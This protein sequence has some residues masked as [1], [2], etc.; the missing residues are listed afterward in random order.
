[1]SCGN[2]VAK[3]GEDE[4]GAGCT[5]TAEIGGAGRGGAGRGG[6]GKERNAEVEITNDVTQRHPM[7]WTVSPARFRDGAHII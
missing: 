7:I 5:S 6:A 2:A 4:H 1:M 3:R